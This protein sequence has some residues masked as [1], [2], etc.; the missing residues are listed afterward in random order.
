MRL[1][2]LGARGFLCFLTRIVIARANPEAIRNY[3]PQNASRS[4]P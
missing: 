2:A 1:R 4:L 3:E